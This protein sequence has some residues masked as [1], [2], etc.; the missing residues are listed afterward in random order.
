MDGTPEEEAFV[1]VIVG[2]VRVRGSGDC[3]LGFRIQDNDIGVASL[4]NHSFS[5]V[6]AVEFGGGFA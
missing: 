5:R 3:S 6:E 1:G 2:V 4:P